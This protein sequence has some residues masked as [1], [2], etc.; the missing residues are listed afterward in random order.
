MT[1]TDD[2]GFL[3]PYSEEGKPTISSEVAEFL[4][5]SAKANHPKEKLRLV[6]RSE[7]I[8]EEEKKKYAA[9]IKN[10]YELKLKEEQRDFRKKTINSVIFAIIGIVALAVMFLLSAKNVGEVWKECIDIFAWVFLW[11][12]VDQF[13]IERGGIMMRKKRFINFLEM[14]IVFLS[15]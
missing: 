10:Y 12:A 2:D 5:T 1:V 4:E 9:A 8:D 15:R 13:F 3:S 14:D 11:E 7:C 6:V